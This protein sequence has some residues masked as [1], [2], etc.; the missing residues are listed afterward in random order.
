MLEWSQDGTHQ[1][2]FHFQKGYLFFISTGPSHPQ[3]SLQRW[4]R[5]WRVLH[6][7]GAS[8]MQWYEH[9]ALIETI[10]S[11]LCLQPF[12]LW[13]VWE[14]G[15]GRL[16]LVSSIMMWLSPGSCHFVLC[17]N[18]ACMSMGV[19]LGKIMAR[20]MENRGIPCDRAAC[21]NSQLAVW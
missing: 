7:K 15:K 12:A 6:G 21:S 8:R 16:K 18:L 14:R 3:H 10:R 20:K 19:C 2:R 13:A 11:I 17:V 4:T 5:P 1:C 9:K